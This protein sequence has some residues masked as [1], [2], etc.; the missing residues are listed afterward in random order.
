MRPNYLITAHTMKRASTAP[1]AIGGLRTTDGIPQPADIDFFDF[2]GGRPGATKFLQALAQ[3]NKPKVKPGHTITKGLI[4]SIATAQAAAKARQCS[5][6]SNLG[7]ARKKRKQ[8]KLDA[9]IERKRIA[10]ETEAKIKLI[11]AEAD[12]KNEAMAAAKAEALLIKAQADAEKD[13]INA[14]KLTKKQAKGQA[15]IIKAQGK[16]DKKS[17][18]G[19]AKIIT[20]EGKRAKKEGKGQKKINNSM[21]NIILAEQG[22]NARGDMAKGILGGMAKVAGAVGGSIVGANA[23]KALPQMIGGGEGNSTMD[24]IVSGLSAGAPALGA[25]TSKINEVDPMEP[26]YPPPFTGH[27]GL[28][29]WQEAEEEKKK[30]EEEKKKKNL[31]IFGGIGAAVLIAIVFIATKK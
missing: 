23:V 22:I 5:D 31:L 10:A 17:S 13:I 12:A 30:E 15:K 21:A 7:G 26:G 9:E 16:A 4:D 19:E 6:M 28:V 11:Q 20:A 24:A 29:E 14:Q 1:I 27:Q 25:L 18:K 3:Q 2:A 8:A